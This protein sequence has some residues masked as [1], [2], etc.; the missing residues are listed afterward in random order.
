MN[1]FEMEEKELK[2]KIEFC[3]LFIQYGK[4]VNANSDQSARAFKL[5]GDFEEELRVLELKKGTGQ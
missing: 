4:L 5:R 2:E 1:K 3:S